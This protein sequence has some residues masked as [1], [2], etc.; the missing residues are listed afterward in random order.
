MTYVILEFIVSNVIIRKKQL[1]QIEIVR[2]RLWLAIM[3]SKVACTLKSSSA[4]VR[5][6]ASM[7]SIDSS[8]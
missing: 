1:I 4:A 6:I 5:Q 2:L 3:A 7:M 8:L